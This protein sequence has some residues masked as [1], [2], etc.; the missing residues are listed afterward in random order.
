[1]KPEYFYDIDQN[2]PEWNEIRRG[3][4]T[5]SEFST[6]LA[7][8]RGGK[9]SVT[10]RKYMLSIVADRLGAAPSDRYTN[11]QMERGHLLEADAVNEYTFLTDRETQ[12]IGFVRRGDAGA[13]PDR[14][15]GDNGLL[16][17]KTKDRHRQLE[18]LLAGEVPSEHRVQIQGQLW[19]CE[20]EFCDFVSYWPGLDLFVKRVERDEKEIKRIEEGVAAFMAE[21]RVTMQELQE[22][23]A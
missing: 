12:L 19:V 9:P 14:L 21:V 15:V 16:E 4:V 5:S 11:A 23:A 10:R 22:K 3:V 17:V 13:S 18:C 7:K 20:R 8:G 1:M 2:S 6:V